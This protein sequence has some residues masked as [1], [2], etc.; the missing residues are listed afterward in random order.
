[1]NGKVIILT[2]PIVVKDGKLLTLPNNVDFEL[3]VGLVQEGEDLE[4]AC[5]RNAKDF[6]LNIEVIKPLHPRISWK[7]NSVTGE[8]VAVVSINYLTKLKED[9]V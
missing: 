9:K 6:D 2:E 5:I 7:N 3:P 8:K 4:E 1:M